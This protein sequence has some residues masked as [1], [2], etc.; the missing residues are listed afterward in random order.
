MGRLRGGL[1][2]VFLDFGF[3]GRERRARSL[4][5]GVVPHL[6]MMRRLRDT[7]HAG[8]QHYKAVENQTK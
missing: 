1:D 4:L 3:G 8:N 7:V 2:L 5:L 6:L